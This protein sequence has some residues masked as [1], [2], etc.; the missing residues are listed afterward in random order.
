MDALEELDLVLYLF[1]P[2]TQDRTLDWV[3]I[4]ERL[5]QQEIKIANLRLREILFKLQKDGH[6][7]LEDVIAPDNS[8]VA[9]ERMI[10]YALTFEGEWFQING[11]YKE[12]LNRKRKEEARQSLYQRLLIL[13]TAVAAIGAIFLF[14]LEFVK[15]LC[16]PLL[17]TP[18][19]AFFNRWK[20][21]TL[22]LNFS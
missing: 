6:V 3:A 5:G 14:V 15:Y 8:V 12:E 13:W 21:P 16:P 22:P 2:H 9:G 18:R 11:G 19:I 20:I 10:F 17:N 7:R 4:T 1:K